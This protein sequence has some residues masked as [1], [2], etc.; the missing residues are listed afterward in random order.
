MKVKNT[1]IYVGEDERILRHREEK[2]VQEQKDRK[3]ISAVQLSEQGSSIFMK[4]QQAQKKAMKIVGDTFAAEHSV[5]TAQEDSRRHI[6]EL[7]EE[8]NYMKGLM[9][10]QEENTIPEEELTEKMKEDNDKKLQEYQRKIN[11]LEGELKAEIASIRGTKIE[12]LKSSPMLKAQGEADKILE[13]ASDE[14]MGMLWEEARDHIDEEQEKKEEQAEKIAEKKEEEEARL[15]ES[16]EE[17]EEQEA[18]MEVIRQSGSED[19]KKEIDELLEK[20]KL[21]EED[22]KGAAVDTQL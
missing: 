20:L 5:D 9:A 21:I 16:K 11:I 2:A 3:N 19:V 4:K 18:M 10:E 8:I 22:L 1:T 6:K 15:K 12:R 7:A 14:I 13:A 17:R